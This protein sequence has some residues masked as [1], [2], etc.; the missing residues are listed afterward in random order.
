[1]AKPRIELQ[2]LLVSTLGPYVKVYFQAP[3]KLTYPCL[4]YERSKI[5]NR[6]ANNRVYQNLKLYTLTL[7]YQDPDSNLPDILVNLPT[8]YHESH[9]VSDNL[10]HDIFSIYF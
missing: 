6:F 4:I 10:H 2:Q 9:F 7:I 3:T 1:M 5:K 8:C